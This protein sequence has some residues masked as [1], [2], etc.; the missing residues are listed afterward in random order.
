M[1]RCPVCGVNNSDSSRSCSRCGTVWE[2]ES[3]E[4]NGSG[5]RRSPVD[6]FSGSRLVRRADRPAEASLSVRNPDAEHGRMKIE[7]GEQESGRRQILPGRASSVMDFELDRRM[8]SHEKERSESVLFEDHFEQEASVAIAASR[9]KPG[10]RFHD[11]SFLDQRP[12]KT[13]EKSKESQKGLWS[14]VSGLFHH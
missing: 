5:R 8:V 1:K 6:D 7:A 3:G 2:A 9:Q 10:E 13:P 11:Q 4:R 14:R 12:E